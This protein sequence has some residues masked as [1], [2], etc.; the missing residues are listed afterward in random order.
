MEQIGLKNS[1]FCQEINRKEGLFK[2]GEDVCLVSF[3][4]IKKRENRK[5]KIKDIAIEKD[6][7][8]ISE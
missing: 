8:E 3:K 2:V 5:N 4:S 1:T 7:D 6:I